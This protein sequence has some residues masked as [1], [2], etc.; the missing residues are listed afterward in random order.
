MNKNHM[1][2]V[3]ITGTGYEDVEVIHPYYGLKGAGFNVDVATV[4][5]LDVKGF[6]GV[7]LSSLLKP[8]KPV[9]TDTLDEKN[10]DVVVIPG[11]LV[12]PDKLRQQKE[13]LT[14]IKA[15]YRSKKLIASICHGPWVLISSGILKGMKATCYPSMIDDLTNAGA[16][17]LDQEVVVD[18]NLIT[19]RRPRDLSIFVKTII[20]VL[21]QRN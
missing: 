21:N 3:I 14:F 13:V 9:A 11:G 4:G 1:H 15:M 19:S 20:D 17:Y 7:P 10:Y 6:W 2:A 18:R 12:A 5:G 8:D 16:K